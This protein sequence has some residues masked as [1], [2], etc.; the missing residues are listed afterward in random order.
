MNKAK[1]AAGF[2]RSG[3]AHAFLTFLCFGTTNFLLGVIAER[4]IHPQSAALVAPVVL[5][6]GT[7]L[8]GLGFIMMPSGQKLLRSAASKGGLLVL[9]LAAGACLAMGMLSLKLGFLADPASKGPITAVASANAVFVALL[10]WLIL[11]ERLGQRRW[12]GI[13]ITLC[14]L[15]LMALST[16]G[17]NALR[18]LGFGLFTLICFGLTNIILK[19][20]GHLGMPSMAAAL[21]VWLTVGVCGAIGMVTLAATGRGIKSLAPFYLVPLA[22]AAGIILGVGMWSLKRGVT[23]GRAGPVVAIAGSNAW[24][25]AL[26]DWGVF[27]HVPSTVKLAGMGI[28]LAG[29]ALLALG[30]VER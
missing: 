15:S 13:L 4:G 18:G 9:A 26:L 23:L 22:L 5:W 29:V 10:A 14:G 20:L 25:V 21:T 11:G 8:L 24:L 28:A 6:L 12:S 1:P 2:Q 16:G 3:F 30:A 17:G 19:V 27:G 7:G